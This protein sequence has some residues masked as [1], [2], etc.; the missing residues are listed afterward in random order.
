[1]QTTALKAKL[2]RARET[3]NGLPAVDVS[4]DE[5]QAMYE[6]RLAELARKR[7]VCYAIKS[8]RCRIHKGH[9]LAQE[10]H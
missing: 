5:Q 10:R 3:V 1:M 8:R 6:A 4:L 2:D 7:C 9:R